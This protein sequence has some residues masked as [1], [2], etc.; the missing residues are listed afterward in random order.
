MLDFP[1]IINKHL[2]TDSTIIGGNQGLGAL[3]ELNNFW[4]EKSNKKVIFNNFEEIQSNYQYF[5]QWVY[6]KN[7]TI[8]ILPILSSHAP[9]YYGIKL[10]NGNI[11]ANSLK[12]PEKA[13]QFK[14]GQSLSYIIDFMKGNEPVFRCYIQGSASQFPMGFPPQNIDNKAFDLA[15]LCVASYKYVNKYP[16]AILEQIKPKHVILAHWENFFLQRKE[17]YQ[18]PAQVPFTNV[19]M[20]LKNY[21]K[22]AKNLNINDFTMPVANTNLVFKF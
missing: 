18:T 22:I 20:F 15:I 4:G 13:A 5:N 8:R 2:N 1:L 14:E 9:H 19:K 11:E 6:I 12:I 16:E 10:Y 3:L 17:L 7:K 21:K